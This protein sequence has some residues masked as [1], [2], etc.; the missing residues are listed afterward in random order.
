MS[1]GAPRFDP[2]E[3][4]SGNPGDRSIVERADLL[5]AARELEA[6]A[7]IDGIRPTEGFDDRVMRAIA[8]QPAPRAMAGAGARPAWFGVPLALRN[9]WAVAG[10]S[11][12]P[13]AVR[14]Q[15][16]AFVL[17]VCLVA[18]SLV[19]AAGALTV[20]GL[21]GQHPDATPSTAPAPTAPASTPTP[22]PSQTPEPTP[23]PG[24]EESPSP[25]T[26]TDPGETTRP[27]ATPTGAQTPRPTETP[28]PTD[29]PQPTDSHGS[30]ESG[31][32]SPGPG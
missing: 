20:G 22:S 14:A 15:A 27:T 9:A 13:L 1:G 5:A 7:G 21:L 23:T 32:G 8:A 18:G 24:I 2:S 12:R 28:E 3:I 25:G 16:L 19:T 31:G 26:T 4:D 10:T 29:T 6:L 11:G 30:D 17:L